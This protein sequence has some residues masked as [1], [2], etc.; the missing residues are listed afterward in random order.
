MSGSLRGIAGEP[1]QV[2]R[3]LE[4]RRAHPGVDI[5]LNGLWRG[6]I[7]P[8]TIPGEDMAVYKC[9]YHLRELLDKLEA[10]LNGPG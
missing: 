10:A 6:A 1:D 3:L 4:F 5:T 8:G 9:A 2:P 7:P